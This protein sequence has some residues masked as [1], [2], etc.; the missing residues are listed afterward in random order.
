[1]HIPRLPQGKPNGDKTDEIQV[2]SE[3]QELY[4]RIKD[5][6]ADEIIKHGLSKTESKLFFY[7]LKL[8]RFGD[9][10]PKVK[11]V[12]ILLATGIGKTAYHAAMSKFEVMGWFDFKH[13]E[14][15]ITNLCTPSKKSAKPNS[16]FGKSD[17]RFVNANQKFGKTNSKIEKTNSEFGK[18]ENESPEPTPCKASKAPHTLQTYTDLLHTLS[19][20]MRE[21]FEK[22]CKKKIEEC[23][24]KIGSRTAWLNKHGAEY[25][26]EFKETYS[27]ALSNPEPIAPK[28]EI[29]SPDILTLQKMYGE[30]WESAAAYY[31][32]ISPNSSNVE[33]A[34]KHSPSASIMGQCKCADCNPAEEEIW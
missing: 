31:G 10:S 29:A 7:L 23:S 26:E 5:E 17:S 24:F 32:L 19:E 4:I 9:K 34:I 15:E 3:T 8:D 16:E 25:L 14:V 12:E 6:V 13:S 20:G 30:N 22:F 11:V 21:S 27:E 18:T 2:E 28:A 33:K 1:M